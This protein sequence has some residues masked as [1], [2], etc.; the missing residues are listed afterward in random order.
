MASK[1][2]ILMVE[3]ENDTLTPIFDEYEKGGDGV[4][5]EELGEDTAP[6]DSTRIDIDIRQPTISNIIARLEE[7]EIDLVPEFQRQQN[8]WPIK[9][10]SQ[11]IESIILKSPLPAFYFDEE[12][13]QN[14]DGTI[15]T[16]WH[17]VDGLQRICALRNFILGSSGESPIRLKGLE[18]LH[19]CENMNYEQLPK[20]YKRIINETQLTAYLMKPSTPIEVKYNVFKRV[21]TGGIPLNQQEIRH[22]LNQ[23]VATRFLTDLADLPEFTLATERKIKAR[24]MQDREL[25]NRFL[26]FYLQGLDA[27]KNMDGYLD[28]ALKLINS[29]KTIEPLSEITERFRRALVV[30]HQALGAMAFRR[31]KGGRINKALFEV[32]TVLVAKLDDLSADIFMRSSDARRKYELLFDNDS[33]LTLATTI[34]TGNLARVRSRYAIVQQYLD[35]IIYE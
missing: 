26:A 33:E 25:V 10:Q 4:E 32:F 34:S 7:S 29:G 2:K 8:L 11:L 13:R 22:A 3:E 20:P 6:F 30:I 1:V 35:D 23:G 15:S 17:V 31:E 24:R 19:N 9:K 27:Y 28:S 21:N 5:K 18:F 14:Q 12:R 16:V